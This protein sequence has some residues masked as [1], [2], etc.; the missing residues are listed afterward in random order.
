MSDRCGCWLIRFRK[1]KAHPPRCHF[2]GRFT[3]NR[4]WYYW[5]NPE[6][7]GLAPDLYW[8]G[9][10]QAWERPKPKPGWDPPPTYQGIPLEGGTPFG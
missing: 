7:F 2:C 9:W 8:V 6:R 10:R 3:T 4:G 1:D 5:L